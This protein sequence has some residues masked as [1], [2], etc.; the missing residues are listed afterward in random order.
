MLA[1]RKYELDQLQATI[2]G[3]RAEFESAR[4]RASADQESN[5]KALVEE[6]DRQRRAS[7]AAIQAERDNAASDI[8]EMRAKAQAEIM[9]ERESLQAREDKLAAREEAFRSER[10][11]FSALLNQ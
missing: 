11:R 1:A 4:I 7:K 8:R 9:A 6:T 5:A 10:A 2:A 3:E